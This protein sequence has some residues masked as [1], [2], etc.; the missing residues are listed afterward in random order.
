M[1]QR[2]HLENP[3]PDSLRELASPRFGEPGMIRI[4]S[5]CC[6]TAECLPR[7]GR[8]AQVPSALAEVV[9]AGR[10]GDGRMRGR[11]ESLPAA[12][13]PLEFTDHHHGS[14]HQ[15]ETIQ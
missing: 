15:L 9:L 14:P 4:D 1:T 7:A 3:F 12:L 10:K 2:G 8:V 5:R 13:R 11:E 6:G